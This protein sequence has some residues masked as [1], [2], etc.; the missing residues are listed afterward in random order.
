[1]M[2]NVSP[3][4]FLTHATQMGAFGGVGALMRI[5]SHVISAPMIDLTQHELSTN[6][7]FIKPLGT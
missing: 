7:D 6:V 3:V 5:P 2:H 1:M 4:I